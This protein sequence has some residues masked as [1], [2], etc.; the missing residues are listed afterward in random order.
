MKWLL[1]RVG[2][3]SVRAASIPAAYT[4]A[5]SMVHL[6]SASSADKRMAFG[7]MQTYDGRARSQGR[8]MRGR[9]STD[10]AWGADWA[11]FCFSSNSFATFL[12]SSGLMMPAPSCAAEALVSL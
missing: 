2:A 11:C 9:L 12:A 1:V 8:S 4:S 3:Q 6:T 7:F 5:P 10:T